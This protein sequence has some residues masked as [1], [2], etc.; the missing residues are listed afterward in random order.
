MFWQN[1]KVLAAGHTGLRRAGSS[2][3]RA[4]I[5]GLALQP[6]TIPNLFEEPT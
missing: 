2:G 5:C 6:P 3:W 4:D 1:R